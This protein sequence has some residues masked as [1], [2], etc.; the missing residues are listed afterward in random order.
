LHQIEN[1]QV[2]I[3]MFSKEAVKTSLKLSDKQQEEIAAITK[4]F[5]KDMRELS[6]GGPGGFGGFDPETIKK[7]QDLQKKA[8]DDARK[9]LTDK[10]K[11]TFKDLTGEPFELRFEG[12]FPGGPGP[13]GPG[14]FPGGP[15]GGGGPGAVGQPGQIMP[16]FVQDQLKLTA[17]QK[18]KL[19]ELQKEID[20]KLDK[21]LTDDQK[22]QLKDMRPGRGP[23]GP[24][25]ERP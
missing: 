5:Q 4:D 18:K 10:Q 9:I 20:G 25:P 23:G 22:K 17:D 1:Q 24:P 14:G 8:M 6:G 16:P 11:E 13:G 21:I 7:R 2:G 3:I 12:G 19:E 15:R